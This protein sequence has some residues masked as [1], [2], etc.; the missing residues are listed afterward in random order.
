MKDVENLI[1]NKVLSKFS[2]GEVEVNIHYIE[3]H[4][5]LVI[6]IPLL[7]KEFDFTFN[8]EDL[9]SSTFEVHLDNV[10]ATVKKQILL[11]QI[12]S[13]SSSLMDLIET[14]RFS[15]VPIDD[16]V[17]GISYEGLSCKYYI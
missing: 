12:E 8:Q 14:N 1:Y 4:L 17:K 5:F 10:L 7:N 9:K 2:K 13:F 6:S 15:T 16:L 11:H 3:N